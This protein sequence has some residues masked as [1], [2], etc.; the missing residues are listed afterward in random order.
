MKLNELAEG[1]NTTVP[2]TDSRLRPD[3]RLL[4]NGDIG[5]YY[6]YQAQLFCKFILIQVCKMVYCH[7]VYTHLIYHWQYAQNSHLPYSEL[8]PFPKLK[9]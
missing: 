2:C 6:K 8:I 7:L 4:E 1:Q 5:E 3:I 9:P